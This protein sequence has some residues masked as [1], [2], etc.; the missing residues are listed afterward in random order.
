MKPHEIIYEVEKLNLA[1][2]LTLVENIWESIALSNS[3]LPL[4]EWQKK[5]LRN[6]Y[7]EFKAGKLAVHEAARVHKD[8]RAK[9]K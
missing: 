2:K 9:G 7:K 4:P 5:E 6:R 8:I 1:E 3:D